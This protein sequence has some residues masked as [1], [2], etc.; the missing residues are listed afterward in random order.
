MPE[1]IQAGRG[2]IF[3]LPGPVGEVSAGGQGVRVLGTRDPLAD[4]QQRSEPVAGLQGHT[5]ILRDG[6]PAIMTL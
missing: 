2:A 5:L 6:I 3:S 4:R 1:L